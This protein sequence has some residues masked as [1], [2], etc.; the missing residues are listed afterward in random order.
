MACAENEGWITHR[1]LCRRLAENKRRLDA[2]RS[3]T[4]VNIGVA[5]QRW[6]KLRNSQGMKTD[7]MV[8]LFLLDR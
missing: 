5:F 3:Q 1:R 6:R 2:E 4:R 7:S 8:A